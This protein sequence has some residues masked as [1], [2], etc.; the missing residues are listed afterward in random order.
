[1]LNE[2]FDKY[3]RSGIEN[4][5]SD[6]LEIQKKLGFEVMD[7]SWKDTFTNIRKSKIDTK[8]QCCDVK[9][10]ISLEHIRCRANVWGAILCIP[11]IRK[12]NSD[13]LA[14]AEKT[15]QEALKIIGTNLIL[16]HSET[17]LFKCLSCNEESIESTYKNVKGRSHLFGKCYCCNPYKRYKY[18]NDPDKQILR[19]VE[20]TLKLKPLSIDKETITLEC[21]ICKNHY[22]ERLTVLKHKPSSHYCKGCRQ[23]RSKSENAISLMLNEC[24][25]KFEREKDFE[26]LVNAENKKLWMDFWLPDFNIAIEY[27]GEQHFR[28]VLFSRSM[29]PIAYFEKLKRHDGIK[30]DWAKK[31][32]INLIRLNYKQKLQESL[33]EN[34]TKFGVIA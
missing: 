7:F 10:Q 23:I 30:N 6:F 14:R 11:C 25:I 28:P 8:C 33:L 19:Y 13:A 18:L 21:T 2:D 24:G 1:M 15:K 4:F 34:L 26:T 12:K 3:F 22:S 9:I 27:D 16:A 17:V 20:K 32:N 5:E 31:N 29:D